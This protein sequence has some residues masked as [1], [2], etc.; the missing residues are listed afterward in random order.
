M[1]RTLQKQLIRV[2]AQTFASWCAEVRELA[3]ERWP[4]VADQAPTL[5]HAAI[6]GVLRRRFWRGRNLSS[7]LAKLAT[8]HNTVYWTAK[9]QKNA[10]RDQLQTRALETMGWR[11]LRFWETD[12]YRQASGI[13]DQSPRQDRALDRRGIGS[14]IRI[15]TVFPFAASRVGPID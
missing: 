4:V 7:Q 3:G 2:P 15:R 14:R 1:A 6:G 11:V 12:V 8:G 9:I 10:E 13:A 5:H